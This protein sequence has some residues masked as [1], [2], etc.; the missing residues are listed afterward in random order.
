MGLRDNF[1]NWAV[2]VD[3]AN[4]ADGEFSP[5]MSFNPGYSSSIYFEGFDKAGLKVYGSWEAD[6]RRFSGHI[7]NGAAALMLF[8][9]RLLDSLGQIRA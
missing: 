1:Y 4:P 7:W 8:L 2:S 9:V 3:S 5:P 6:Q